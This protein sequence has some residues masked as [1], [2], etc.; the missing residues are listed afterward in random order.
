VSNSTLAVILFVAAFL[1][2]LAGVVLIV[3][4]IRQDLRSA[5]EIEA[6]NAEPEPEG[7]QT[8]SPTHETFIGGDLG[9][10]LARTMQVSDSFREFTLDRLSGGLGRRILGVVLFVLGAA[11]GLAGNLIAL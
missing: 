4:E 9:R 11:V 8:F 5:R 10:H 1:L 3:L 2:Q 6:Q 7:V